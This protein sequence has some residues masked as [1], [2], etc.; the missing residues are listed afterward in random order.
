MSKRT[1]KTVKVERE[2]W[3]LLKALSAKRGNKL[4]EEFGRIVVAEAK[5]RRIITR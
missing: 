4:Y 5:R 3:L 1:F 2:G